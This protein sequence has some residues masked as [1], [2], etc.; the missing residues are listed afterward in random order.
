LVQQ[1]FSVE[2]LTIAGPVVHR[3]AIQLSSEYQV[4]LGA[5]LAVTLRAARLKDRKNLFFKCERDGSRRGCS[6]L[7]Q[8]GD[9]P[10]AGYSDSNS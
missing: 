2:P 6:I 7:G 8:C 3:S 10:K 4:Q 1:A 9:T 5:K